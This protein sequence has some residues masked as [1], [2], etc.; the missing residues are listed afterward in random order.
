M[1]FDNVQGPWGE[2]AKM[3]FLVKNG[4]NEEIWEKSLFM[5]NPPRTPFRDL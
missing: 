3:A 5:F 2:K 1:I 4:E